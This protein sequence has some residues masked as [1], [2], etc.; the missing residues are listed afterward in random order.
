MWIYITEWKLGGGGNVKKL[1]NIQYIYVTKYILYILCLT[2]LCLGL[3]ANMILVL[4]FSMIYLFVF[5]FSFF[6][7]FKISTFSKL[8]KLSK[9]SHSRCCALAEKI[10]QCKLTCRGWILWFNP[11]LIHWKFLDLNLLVHGKFIDL[12][13]LVQGIFTDLSLLVLIHFWIL[14]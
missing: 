3:R 13:S 14:K 11:Y 9:C 8:C 12:S 10:P 1:N 6:F 2:I 4:R 7:S 5:R